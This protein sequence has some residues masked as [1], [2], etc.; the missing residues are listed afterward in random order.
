MFLGVATKKTRRIRG[1]DLKILDRRELNGTNKWTTAHHIKQIMRIILFCRVLFA[2]F[3]FILFHS[4][5][6]FLF[7]Y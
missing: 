6:C 2:C 7:L 4:F 1:E 5:L 3:S